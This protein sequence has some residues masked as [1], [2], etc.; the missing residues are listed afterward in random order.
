MADA[1]ESNVKP[2]VC[3]GGG[4]ALLG[5][6]SGEQTVLFMCCTAV[7]NDVIQYEIIINKAGYK[8]PLSHQRK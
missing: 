3:G 1:H 7:G 5:S 2:E 6:V 8:S 4:V